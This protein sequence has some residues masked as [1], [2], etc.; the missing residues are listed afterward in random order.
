MVVRAMSNLRNPVSAR[1]IL[2]RDPSEVTDDEARI[3]SAR[4]AVV[5]ALEVSYGVQETEEQRLARCEAEHQAELAEANRAVQ[6]AI[7]A[8][9]E[10]EARTGTLART[11]RAV[12]FVFRTAWY[13]VRT[14]CAVFAVKHLG[15]EFGKA[16][17]YF[18][19]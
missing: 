11:W 3:A 12:R 8:Y 15:W 7:N 5:N 10:Q 13:G 17:L 19:L 18:K 9:Y 1:D 6:D 14:N 16:W 4:A 2:G